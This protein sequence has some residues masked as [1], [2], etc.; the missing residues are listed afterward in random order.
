MVSFLP[1]SSL[2]YASLL[3]TLAAG[4]SRLLGFARDVLI[5]HLLGAG[6]VADAFLIA[7][8]LPNLIRRV[9]NEGGLNASFVPLYLALKQQNGAPAAHAFA[10][11]ALACLSLF[12]LV[13]IGF[14]EIFTEPLVSLF[15]VAEQ[16]NP[17]GVLVSFY[18]RLAFPLVAF[19]ALA[20]LLAAILNSEGHVLAAAFAPLVVNSVSVVVLVI[21]LSRPDLSQ[22]TAGAWLAAAVTVSGVIH[23]TI[24]IIALRRS[25]FKSLSP[26]AL[27]PRSLWSHEVKTCEIKTREIKTWILGAGPALAIMGSTHFM[28]LIAIHSAA[29]MPSAVSWL[30]Y[31]DRI[32]QLPLGLVGASM[33]MVLLPEIS[34]LLQRGQMNEVMQTQNR[35]LETA[36][37]VSCPAAAALIMLALPLS[38]ILFERG[39]FNAIDSAGTAA[40]LSGFA[41]G[42]P[43]AAAGK[44]LIQTFLARQ[45]LR[46]AFIIGVVSVMITFAL[47]ALLGPLWG[48][49]GIALGAS[50]GMAAALFLLAGTLW[51]MRMFKPDAR[52]FARLLRILLATT[53]M[54]LFL[55]ILQGAFQPWLTSNNALIQSL[56]LMS[57]CLMGLIFYMALAWLLKAVTRQD[58]NVFSAPSPLTRI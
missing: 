10:M 58:L 5:A 4:L 2:A 30:Y 50:L 23:F 47:C 29:F 38:I 55:Y 35:A 41:C 20:A 6:S 21:L 37:L 1:R 33:S 15:G 17:Q 19:I 13:L 48:I 57:L 16:Q 8:W 18:I 56:A 46:P 43:F 45:A 27:W 11:Q 39:A 7:F 51:H 31:A 26:D 9:L 28:L 34:R 12:L 42:L 44:V 24:L 22:A 40:A 49:F 3:V 32:F 53:G 52:L 36:F 54:M 14:V 25:N